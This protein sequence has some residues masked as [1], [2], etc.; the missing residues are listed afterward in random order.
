[1]ENLRVNFESWEVD[2]SSDEPNDYKYFTRIG[3][4]LHWG[5]A[6]ET[7]NAGDGVLIPCPY[8]VVFILREDN[9]KIAE[10]LPSQINV[11]I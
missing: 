8:T 11:M 2:I 5:I 6:T 9:N 7:Q 4:I 1:M 10:V 3:R